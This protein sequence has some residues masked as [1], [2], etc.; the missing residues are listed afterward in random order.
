MRDGYSNRGISTA[1]RKESATK[2]IADFL[3]VIF[4]SS[5]S[6]RFKRFV[7]CPNQSPGWDQD[8]RLN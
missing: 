3:G 5:R 6:L 1:G 8:S 7:G 4:T 2:V